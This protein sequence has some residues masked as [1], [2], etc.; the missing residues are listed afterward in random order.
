MNNKLAKKVVPLKRNKAKTRQKDI[1]ETKSVLNKAVVSKKIKKAKVSDGEDYRTE[2]RKTGDIGENVACTFLV[3]QGFKVLQRNFLKPFGELDVIALKDGVYHFIEVKTVTQFGG[4]VVELSEIGEP[5]VTHETSRL[6]MDEY[7]PEDN[8]HPWKLKR[9]TRVIQAYIVENRL[10]EME[11]KFDVV[12][13]SLNMDT[14]LA[15][16]NFIEDTVL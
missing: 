6:I 16:V 15:K 12:T 5:D 10:F 13:V 11:W 8:L 14:R 1:E 7:R 2:K 3:K 4:T 9:I